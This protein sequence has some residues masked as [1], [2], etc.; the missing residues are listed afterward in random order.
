MSDRLSQVES[1]LAE[2]DEIVAG[3]RRRLDELE[4]AHDRLAE[5]PV[6]AT[7]MP[8]SAVAAGI[9][10]E[11]R[12]WVSLAGRLLIILGGAFLLRAL[13]ESDRLPDT[14]GVA[15]GLLYMLVWLGLAEYATAAPHQTR[16][17]HGFAALL[18][19]L[20]LLWE[21][22]ERFQV[23]DSASGAIALSGV[24]ALS[25]GVAGHRNVKS[26][27]IASTVGTIGM[28]FAMTAA[29][30][31]RIPYAIPALVLGLITWWLGERRQWRSLR[32][33]AGLALDLL[34]L[35]L[36]ARAT[37]D[38]ARE[39]P[40]I[41]L[42]ALTILVAVT[43]A[44]FAVKALRGRAI[45]PFEAVQTGALLS[46]GAGGAAA[47]A[48]VLSAPGPVAVG[49]SGMLFAAIAYAA[50][51]LADA[52][53]RSHALRSYFMAVGLALLVFA[54][55]L[56]FD[57][58]M[59]T[60]TLG[61][62]ALVSA[63]ANLSRP[64]VL[65]LI[66]ATI[67]TIAVVFASGLPAV[68]LRAW[69]PGLTAWPDID[70][71]WIAGATAIGLIALWRDS[72]TGLDR[73]A[74]AMR[75]LLSAIAAAS[76]VTVVLIAIGRRLWPGELAAADVA[77]YKTALVVLVAFGLAIAC[78]WTHRFTTEAR[79]L[80]YAALAFGGLKLLADDLWVAGP[81][82]MFIA[83]GLYGLA[84]IVAPRLARVRPTVVRP[85]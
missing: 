7:R 83:L 28:L 11:A 52:R 49:L 21:A 79:W 32:W 75:L 17:V 81:G 19:G 8:P 47:I 64:S 60:W 56:L 69:R 54:V 74:T 20:P 24:S 65:R 22:S 27:A 30:D 76:L 23:L 40:V 73:L 33:F 36:V 78:R 80:G 42:A 48:H 26:L 12:G 67:V 10:A 14:T 37:A 31:R 9:A 39:S 85:L 29:T 61:A 45:S 82:A 3:L 43:L 2:L 71:S 25:L 84:L 34:L 16:A 6:A 13:T 51:F 41:V 4:H 53:D 77:T 15:L 38:P 1:R 35:G 55:V 57:N 70:L 59:R 44:S 46:I 5:A 63:A 18:V 62:I 68:V 72:S 66:H 58:P 50:P